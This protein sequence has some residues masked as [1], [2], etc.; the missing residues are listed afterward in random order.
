LKLAPFA[1]KHRT[2]TRASAYTFEMLCRALA[3]EKQLSLSEADAGG[4]NHRGL[5]QRVAAWLKDFGL[6]PLGKAMYDAE[7][8][9]APA[10]SQ[11]R[12][13]W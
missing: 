1:F 7:V 9:S 4:P 6:A 5:L 13:Y 8:E 3:Q 2:L 12:A 10:A 11:K